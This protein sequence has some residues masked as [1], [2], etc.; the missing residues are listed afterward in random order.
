[1][2]ASQFFQLNGEEKKTMSDKRR[3]KRRKL[4]LGTAVIVCLLAVIAFTQYKPITGWIVT[5]AGEENR[6]PPGG[7]DK[8]QTVKLKVVYMEEGYFMNNYGKAFMLRH[9]NVSFEVL[10]AD[11]GENY[12]SILEPDVVGKMLEQ[13]QPDVLLM[14]PQAYERMA[15]EGNLLAL[16]T[17]IARDR[18]DLSS[19]DPGIMDSLRQLGGG[20]LY[21]LAPEVE[22]MGLFF[23]RDLFETQG[24]PVPT[25]RMSW[26]DVLQLAARFPTDGSGDK[27]IY[28]LSL[29]SP[30]TP[31]ELID[32]MGRTS[33]LR[34]IG[35][36]DQGL[37][38][39]TAG[40]QEI[41]SMALDAFKR[42]FVLWEKQK[43]NN[44]FLTGQ[45]AMTIQSFQFIS[46]L[47]EPGGA[48]F[49]WDVVTEPVDL[50]NPE[51][52]ATFNIPM[53][54][55][56]NARSPSVE[57]AWELV[58]FINSKEIAAKQVRERP[59][60]PLL[61]RRQQL[62][63]RMKSTGLNANIEAFYKLKPGMRNLDPQEVMPLG[64]HKTLVELMDQEA[65][66]VLEKG[67]S[68][69]EALQSLEKLAREEL[70][71]FKGERNN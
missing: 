45:V 11:K 36:D 18:F 19:I 26:K 14:N 22:R 5:I 41:W 54:F 6:L 49:S 13:D 66:E 58:K 69:S 53:I 3:T 67:K 1:M 8:D 10:T 23:N 35:P 62:L 50:A 17:W 71:R 44:P 55:A 68:L 4:Q 30:S 27:R 47:R 38:L 7:I 29:P 37:T 12:L 42:G 64:F 59:D 39:R 33:G 25:D 70:L 56:V 9:P 43:G 31:G 32:L 21:G 51:V 2:E 24:V 61:S 52:S 28:G 40:W 48:D 20:M 16:D 60:I 46:Q 34:V 65:T 63:E 57:A 15:G